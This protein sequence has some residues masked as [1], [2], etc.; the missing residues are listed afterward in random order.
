MA[1]GSRGFNRLADH[2]RTLAEVPSQVSREAAESI[3][4]S[5]EL[6][7]DQGCDPYGNPW[8][9]L[10]PSTIAR[11]RFPPPLTDSHD[12][13]DSITVTP[14][15]GSGIQID[16]GEDYGIYHQKTRP[17]LPEAEMPLPWKEA[18]QKS[19]DNSVKRRL[20]K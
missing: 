17:I 11:G 6:Q 3:K 20:K 7:F 4:A 14:M 19:F 2:Y 12:L 1:D 5:I 18:I 8:L 9:P 16:V 15:S 13:R 10:A